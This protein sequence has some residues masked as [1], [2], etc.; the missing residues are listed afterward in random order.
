MTTMTTKDDKDN[1]DDH[2]DDHKDDDKDDD[3][4]DNKD[5]DDKKPG[6]SGTISQDIKYKAPGAFREPYFMSS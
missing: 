2:K 3:N 1:D 6:M 4:D 5:D